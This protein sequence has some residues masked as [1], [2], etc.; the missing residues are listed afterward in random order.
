VGIEPNNGPALTTYVYIEGKLPTGAKG[1][2]FLEITQDGTSGEEPP[3]GDNIPVKTLSFWVN[4]GKKQTYS[5]FPESAKWING[6]PD[7]NF[8]GIYVDEEKL[9]NQK[10]TLSATE[11]GN[12][13]HVELQG[14]ETAETYDED[15]YDVTGW[16]IKATLQFDLEKYKDGYTPKVRILNVRYTED[17]VQLGSTDTNGEA[18]SGEISFSAPSAWVDLYFN[19]DMIWEGNDWYMKN[20]YHTIEVRY[21]DNL[22]V[23]DY[24]FSWDY[25]S[26]YW[27][28]L[29][30]YHYEWGYAK[31]DKELGGDQLNLK[32]EF[33]DTEKFTEWLTSE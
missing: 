22:D 27:G 23:N 1:T 19:Q 12:L 26:D 14:H 28:H 8:M 18:K 17:D 5:N 2:G 6:G 16:D 29:D 15:E 21:V 32:M 24:K 7:D 13:L 20:T 10:Y 25:K 31:K 3:L 33:S 9:A 11:N 4:V 30:E